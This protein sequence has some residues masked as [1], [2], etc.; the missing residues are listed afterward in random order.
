[1]Q[2]L[3][4][5]VNEIFEMM[6]EMDIKRIDHGS[7]KLHFESILRQQPSYSPEVCAEHL[8]GPPASVTLQCALG[9][10]PSRSVRAT[11]GTRIKKVVVCG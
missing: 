9:R 5:L 7:L 6:M 8:P 2:K 4:I 10:S 3:I 1:M 11:G